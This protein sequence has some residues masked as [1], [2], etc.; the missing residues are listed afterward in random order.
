MQLFTR[1]DL[2]R[3]TQIP[4]DVLNYWMRENVLR[5][6]E[7]GSGR[8]QHRR[9]DYPEVML[10]AIMDQL[11]GFGLNLPTLRRLAARFHDARDYMARLG[12]TQEIYDPISN[13][14]NL[15]RR[16]DADGF[17]TCPVRE[18]ERGNYPSLEIYKAQYGD[19]YSADVTLEQAMAHPDLWIGPWYDG[20]RTPIKATANRFIWDLDVEEFCTQSGYWRELTMITSKELDVPDFANAGEVTI[21]STPA[22]F[23]RDTAGDWHLTYDAAAAGRGSLSFIGVNLEVLSWRL[24]RGDKGLR[25]A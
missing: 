13:L 22:Y 17:A 21:S 5:P 8:G 11:R 1:S 2:G 23:Y 12:I 4:D 10:A 9:F 25:H 14:V 7:G 6:V 19:Q 3:I 16:V 20:E 24:W 15:K 18:D